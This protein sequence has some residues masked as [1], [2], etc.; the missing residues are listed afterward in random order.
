MRNRIITRLLLGLGVVATL[1]ACSDESKYDLLNDKAEGNYRVSFL[2]SQV[3]LEGTRSTRAVADDI[4]DADSGDLVYGDEH[5]IGETGNYV[6]FFNSNQTLREVTELTLFGP[7]THPNYDIDEN[8]E[9]LYY[10]DITVDTDYQLPAYC[11]VV[12]NA[13]T[14][15]SQLE[16]LSAG[17][18]VAQIKQL[19]WSGNVG[20]TADGLFTMTSSVYG[21]KTS[22]VLDIVPPTAIIKKPADDRPDNYIIVHVERMLA[23][24][25]FDVDTETSYYDDASEE[26]SRKKRIVKLEDGNYRIETKKSGELMIFTGFDESNGAQPQYKA[27]KWAIDLTGW[28]VNA[29]EKQ[30]YLFKDISTAPSLSFTWN[31]PFNYRSYWAKDLN[32]EGS[33]PWQY[34]PAHDVTTTVPYYAQLEDGNILANKSFNDLNLVDKEFGYDKSVYAPENTYDYNKLNAGLD[35]RCDL[36]AGTHVIVGAQI[37]IDDGHGTEEIKDNNYEVYDHLYRDRNGFF[38]TS[39][40]DC[41]RAQVFNFNQIMQSHSVLRFTLYNW[42]NAALPATYQNLVGKTIYA[43]IDG[44]SSLYEWDFYWRKN[45]ADQ[46]QRLDRNTVNS[47]FR[48]YGLKMERANIKNGDGRRMPWPDDGYLTIRGESDGVDDD[49]EVVHVSYYTDP[50]CTM[51]I[52]LNERDANYYVLRD[53]FAKSI[54]YEWLGPVDHFN[55][56]YMYYATPA[57]IQKGTGSNP[58]VCGVVRNAWYDYSL[59]DI[60]GTG[61][62]VDELDKPIIPN[63]IKYE[64]MI[65]VTISI[66]DWH[67]VYTH[68]TGLPNSNKDRYNDKTSYPYDVDF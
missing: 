17:T 14:M 36:L 1:T 21:G 41:M 32:Y 58:D 34:R 20:Q 62:P 37:V 42:R 48:N 25:S 47:I 45:T 49:V 4:D 23:K 24:F 56:G 10:T 16:S 27:R 2:I 18:T 63:F 7:E 61:T 30:S 22:D 5:K 60:S 33:Y 50:E 57:V 15:A 26:L 55:N 65:G 46:G 67:Y 29:F 6:L 53:I 12:L 39:E 38:Y 68:A 59:F 40:D 11:M 51:E 31:D 52:T 13:G 54:M 44:E 28:D 9:A 43:K 64:D 19:V 35:G 66:L 8:I 3:G